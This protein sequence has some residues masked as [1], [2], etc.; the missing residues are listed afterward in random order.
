MGD[1]LQVRIIF[2][3]ISMLLV[4][5][6]LNAAAFEWVFLSD[7]QG[8]KHFIDKKSIKEDSG[9]RWAY[10]KSEYPK[11]QTGND[12]LTKKT[13]VFISAVSYMAVNCDA[14]TLTPLSTNYINSSGKVT[15]KIR[16]VDEKAIV[17]GDKTWELDSNSETFR[18]VV[19]NYVCKEK[20]LN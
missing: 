10:Y 1:I 9:F 12:F 2:F 14:K 16:Y 6:S 17:D 11:E 3:S 4:L 8:R 18:P 19:I 5:F 7:M 20:V 13:Y 15:H